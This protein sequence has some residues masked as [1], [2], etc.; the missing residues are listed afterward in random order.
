[1]C[2]QIEVRGE[3][4]E[5]RQNYNLLEYFYTCKVMLRITETSWKQTQARPTGD[6]W[7][8]LVKPWVHPND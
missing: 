8:I 5:N 3:K 1:M 4:A 7:K 6:Y 2:A